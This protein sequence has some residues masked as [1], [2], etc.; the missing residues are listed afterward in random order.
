MYEHILVALDGSELAERVLPHA[1]ALAG[2]FGSSVTLL[3]AITSLDSI[4]AATAPT[5]MIGQPVVPYPSVDPTELLDAERAEATEYLQK[6]AERLS[7]G[8]IQVTIATPEGPASDAIVDHAH[9]KGV[10]LVAMTTHGRG[11]LG[12]LI[13]GSVADDVLRRVACPLL[14]VRVGEESGRGAGDPT[15]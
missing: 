11:G 10:N 4:L 9:T 8:G 6:V 12:R 14:L 2:K 3:R 13:L 5:P 15:E 1:E 7:K